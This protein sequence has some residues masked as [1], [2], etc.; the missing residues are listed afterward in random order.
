MKNFF[1]KQLIKFQLE[2]LLA[3]INPKTAPVI[4]KKLFNSILI[5]AFEISPSCNRETVSYEKVEK[6]VNAPKNPT[7]KNSLTNGSIASLSIVNTVKTASI[8]EPKVF[9]NKVP[10]GNDKPNILFIYPDTKYL[11]KAPKLPPN[12]TASISNVNTFYLLYK[13]FEIITKKKKSIF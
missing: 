13:F 5:N 2:K 7:V 8:N 1:F 3:K 4:D 12:I 10:A 11:L 9:T 6:V